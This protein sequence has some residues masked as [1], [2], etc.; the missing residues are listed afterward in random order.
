MPK[1]RRLDDPK[2]KTPLGRVVNDDEAALWGAYTQGVVPAKAAKRARVVKPPPAS[3]N[4]PTASALPH[5]TPSPSQSQV[6][7]PLSFD[8]RHAKKLAGGKRAIDARLDLHGLRQDEAQ[9]AL[10]RFLAEAQRRG[11]KYVKVITGKGRSEDDVVAAFGLSPGEGRGVL[12]RLV[13]IWLGSAELA[14]FV[15]GFTVAGRGHG[16]DGA[17]YVHVRRAQRRT[18]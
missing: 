15:V 16:G 1:T 4:E 6:R 10:R 5:H 7:Q 17:L 14:P 9:R 8:E 12:R 13:P 2:P 3:R 18:P 11:F